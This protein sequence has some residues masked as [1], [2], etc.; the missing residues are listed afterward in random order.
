MK[1]SYLTRCML[2]ISLIILL[3]TGMLTGCLSPDDDLGQIFQLLA[4]FLSANTVPVPEGELQVHFLDVGQGEAVL[5]QTAEAA[6]LIDGGP[7]AAGS[8]VVDYLRGQGITELDIIIGTHPHEDHIGGLI[9][10]MERFPVAEVIDPAVAHTTLT[11]E[12]Y[13]DVIDRKEIKF[14]EGRAGMTRTLSGGAVLDI[15][16]PVSPGTANLNDASV[17]ARL[18]FGD[19]V[20]L[21]TGDAE[22]A[23]EKEMLS[24]RASLKSTVLKAGHH[25]S[26]T[27]TTAAFLDAVDPDVVIISSGKDNPYGHPH[28]EVIERLEE[29]DI[30]VY[31]TDL[32]GTIVITTDG[33]E[34]TIY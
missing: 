14:T 19:A 3:N 16:H 27:S 21:F 25:G 2:L 29:R 24:R 7:R 9:E 31:R 12:D 5:I 17:V 32:D 33:A 30:M 10:V 13:L 18:R 8:L 23:S 26:S 6:V 34:Y 15:L 28:Q 20:F 22:E 1:K 11:F 4:E